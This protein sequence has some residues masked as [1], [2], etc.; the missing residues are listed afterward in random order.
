LVSYEKL[1]VVCS[2]RLS[3]PNLDDLCLAELGLD[4]LGLVN[5]SLENL[6][7]DELSAFVVKSELHFLLQMPCGGLFALCAIGLFLNCLAET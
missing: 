4:E 3:N 1:S 6:S 5:P 2:V 7:R